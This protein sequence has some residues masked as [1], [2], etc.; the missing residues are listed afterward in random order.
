MSSQLLET[1][2]TNTHVLVES[3]DGRLSKDEAR[4]RCL[5][6]DNENLIVT[7]LFNKFKAAQEANQVKS[8]DNVYGSASPND[9]K[10]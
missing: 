3:P 6:P 2:A 5:L 9:D 7:G 8:N 1:Q 10:Q 4:K